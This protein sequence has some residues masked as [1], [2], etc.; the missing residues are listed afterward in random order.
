MAEQLYDLTPDEL[1]ALKKENAQKAYKGLQDQ[2]AA[3]QQG[4]ATAQ[5]GLE[6]IATAEK[7]ALGDVRNK[8]ALAFTASQ[9]RGGGG[10]LAGM[11]QSQL[12]RGVAEGATRGEF[13][14]QRIQQDQAIN[15]A[16]KAAARASTD[17]ATEGEKLRQAA[18][19]ESRGEVEGYDEAIADFQAYI[20]ENVTM[21]ATYS[22]RQKAT[23]LIRAKM[24]AEPNPKKRAGMQRAIDAIHTGKATTAKWDTSADFF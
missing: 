21:F 2:E 13:A 9:G 5:K 4:V 20:D 3:A 22:A 23:E 16:Q 24:R 12:A 11:R 19:A 18:E 14:G 15:E 10:S 8:S 6:Q 1:Y 17:V 7:G